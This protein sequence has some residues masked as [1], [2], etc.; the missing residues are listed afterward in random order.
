MT[1]FE[2]DEAANR[3]RDEVDPD[4]NIIFGSTFDKQLEGKVRISVVATGIEA[5]AMSQPRPALTLVAKGGRVMN[6][7]SAEQAMHHGA[8]PRAR[9]ERVPE[10]VAQTAQ[11]AM[12]Q[13]FQQQTMQV[14][15][16]GGY[17]QRMTAPPAP[18]Y[19]NEPA[20]QA[21]AP[22]YVPRPNPVEPQE[23]P[24]ARP[25]PRQPASAAELP[26]APPPAVEYAEPEATMAQERFVPAPP[27]AEPVRPAAPDRRKQGGI[28]ARAATWAKQTSA[29]L[30]EATPAAAMNR[31]ASSEPAMRAAATPQ[32][33]APA[34]QPP[35]QT[36]LTGLDPAERLA[37]RQS[38]D[39]ILDIPAFLRRQAN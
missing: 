3:I 1:L 38:E 19:R 31:I 37:S 30:R 24:M 2:V 20:P 25:E 27:V 28:L 11:P 17:A 33:A 16:G 36:V 34:A 15:V 32:R 29:E 35:S 39:E 26:F 21:A 8:M 13:P 14:A 5:E 18:A 6:A 4:A 12:Q 10:I 7:P 22:S 23:R 9:E